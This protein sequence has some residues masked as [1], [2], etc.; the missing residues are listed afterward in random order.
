MNTTD[1]TDTTD[2]TEIEKAE[3]AELQAKAERMKAAAKAKAEIAQAQNDFQDLNRESMST[4]K[5]NDAVTGA[6]AVATL[7]KSKIL[8]FLLTFFFSSLGLFYTNA[9]LAIIWFIVEVVL[10]IGT[11]GMSMFIT[12]PLSIIFGLVSAGN[13]NDKIMMMHETKV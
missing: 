9:I 7:G 8:S 11:M 10:F 2:T 4:T 3:L 13:T 1:T 5:R 12:W 6:L